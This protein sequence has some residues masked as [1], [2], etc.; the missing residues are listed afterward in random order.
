MNIFQTRMNELYNL[1]KYHA[2]LYYDKDSPEISDFE[3][4]SLVRELNDLE[5]EHPEFKRENF[6]THNVGGSVSNLFSPVNHDIPMLSLD[7]VFTSEELENFFMRIKRDNKFTCEMKIDGLAVSLIYQDGQLIQ[8]ATRGNGQTG[9]NV[10]ENI[11]AIDSIPKKLINYPS[12]QIEVRGE[13][14]MTLDR[15]NALNQ[16]RTERGEK[17]FAN[18][19]NAAAGTLRQKDKRII[20]ERGLDIFLYYV[21]NAESFGITS[22]IKSLEFL[23][24]LGLPVQSA[25]KYCENLDEVNNFIAHWQNERYNLNYITDGVVI[26]LD[27]L[28][29]WQEIGSTSHAPR[30]AVAYKY[31][32]E[33]VLT[34]IK[35]IKI[36]V[37]RTG[38]LTP[39]AILE[40]VKL[41][42]T[43][44][45]RAGLHNYDEITRKDIRVGDL[46]RVRKAAEIIPEII[47]VD[48]SARKGSE[49]IFTMPENC[50][51]CESEVVRLPGEIAYRCTNRASCPAQLIEGLKYFAS[52]SGMNIKGLGDSLAAKLIESGLVK[53][54]SDIY[55]LKISDWLKLDKIANKSAENI[56]NELQSS[57]TRPLENLITALGIPDVGKN[58]AA[59]L[60]DRFGNIDALKSASESDIAQIEGIGP[61]I[62]KSVHEFFRNE[63]NLNLIEN[64]RALGL[65][66]TSNNII[67]NGQ[68]SGKIFVFTGSL[69]SMTREQAA[70]RVKNLGGR[71]SESVS[72]KTSY[73]VA[74]DKT[75][76]K[77]EKANKLGVK[78]LSEQEFIS[79]ISDT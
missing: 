52:R 43:V 9:E 78:I 53:C 31:P 71:V 68:L 17:T 61:I 62:A 48:K 28:T 22:Q 49:K 64:F 2:G 5:R 66:M 14:L 4:D 57:K 7:N 79:M 36:S 26:K 60:V 47:E 72:K 8:G 65:N 20:S 10:T 51:V 59:L 73:L 12:G 50:P 30:W 33:E 37:G 77:L 44:V 42:G 32:P 29:Q 15:F 70:E 69:D 76:S 1:V 41:A 13:I 38:V 11:L 25:Y 23:Q 3:Y 18:P 21:V 35:D 39:V 74:G 40:P 46:A 54:L 34:R 75:G 27:D 63:S 58:A 24:N 19:R 16:L 45:Q 67:V 55:S 56:M 6:L